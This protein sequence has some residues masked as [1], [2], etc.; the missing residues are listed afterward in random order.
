[1]PHDVTPD[2][3][4]EAYRWGWKLGLKALAI[5]RDGSKQSQPLSTQKEGDKSGETVTE[6]VRGPHRETTARNSAILDT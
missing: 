6:V 3:I 1:M 4:S 2:D 5:Y